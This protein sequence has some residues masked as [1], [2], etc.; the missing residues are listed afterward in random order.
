M[1][2]FEDARSER[3]LYTGWLIRTWDGRHLADQVGHILRSGGYTIADGFGAG[4]AC[5]RPLGLAEFLAANSPF[6]ID[7]RL[8]LDHCRRRYPTSPHPSETWAQR[9]DGRISWRERS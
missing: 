2:D 6:E 7:D 1:L 8:W 5:I 3:D 4:L 9:N